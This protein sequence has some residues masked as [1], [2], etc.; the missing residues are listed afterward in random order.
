MILGPDNRGDTSMRDALRDL[1]LA[2]AK[3][4]ASADPASPSDVPNEETADEL[5]A[6][7]S[8]VGR[9]ARSADILPERVVR[10]LRVQ[11]AAVRPYLPSDD[12][13]MTM[14]VG[15]CLEAY[16]ADADAASE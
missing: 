9:L 3:C 14:T 16:F 5:R 7:A 11:F 12:R 13:L 1:R 8:V 15:W 6:A 10:G 4:L 2:F